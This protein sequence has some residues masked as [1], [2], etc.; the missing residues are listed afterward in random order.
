[1]ANDKMWK[2]GMPVP[3]DIDGKSAGKVDKKDAPEQPGSGIRV[4]GKRIKPEQAYSGSAET[5]NF[6]PMV[7]KARAAAG[8]KDKESRTNEMGDTYKNGGSVS[9]SRRADGIASKGKTRG[10]MC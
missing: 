2:P 5:P 9:A 6:K 3:Q 7:D 1:M 8:R 10:K 4:D